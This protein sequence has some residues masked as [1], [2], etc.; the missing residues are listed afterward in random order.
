[1]QKRRGRGHKTQNW[2]K[3]WEIFSG[4]REVQEEGWGKEEKN[5]RRRRQEQEGNRKRVLA[6]GL[7]VRLLAGQPGVGWKAALARLI[8]H[9]PTQAPD[10][11]L[12]S[13]ASTRHDVPVTMCEWL[14]LQSWLGGQGLLTYS[15]WFSDL[16]LNLRF[17]SMH[18]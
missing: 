4:W 16:L 7:R 6:V 17:L 13:Q 12:G 5:K 2:G 11:R 15:S 10:T 8:R 3:C 1:M 9:S 14:T 18:T